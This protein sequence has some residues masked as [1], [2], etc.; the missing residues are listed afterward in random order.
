MTNICLLAFA[1]LPANLTASFLAGF[2]ALFFFFL[3]V[4]FFTAGSF[5]LVADA[6]L[7]RRDVVAVL[8]FLDFAGLVLEMADFGFFVLDF[9]S[10]IYL[11]SRIWV[12][13]YYHP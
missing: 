10:P 7:L 3:D 4:V 1:G 11:F 9:I 8:L 6:V 2:L 5:L 12:C 13:R